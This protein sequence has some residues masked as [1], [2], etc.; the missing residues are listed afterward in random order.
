V[1]YVGTFSKC[2]L[3]ALRLGFVIA[4]AWAMLALV[5]VEHRAFGRDLGV[6]RHG[7]VT[8]PGG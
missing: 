2:M 3:P 1:L 6:A 5:A 4:P 7:I 8:P